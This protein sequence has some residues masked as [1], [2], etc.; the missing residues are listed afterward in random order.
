MMVPSLSAIL[1]G[2]C[3]FPSIAFRLDIVG[4]GCSA[5]IT[6]I[7]AATTF[8]SQHPSTA[9]LV[10]CAEI[11]S[12]LFSPPATVDEMIVNALFADAAAAVTIKADGHRPP[13]LPEILSFA[14]SLYPQF[15]GSMQFVP[16]EAGHGWTFALDRRVSR[17][18]GDAAADTVGRLL[19]GADVPSS[20]VVHWLLHGGG[21]GVTQAVSTSLRIPLTALSDTAATIRNFGNVSSCSVIFALASLLTRKA[22]LPGDYG[23]MIGIG[24]GASIETA[25]LRW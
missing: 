3:A 24:P 7:R 9:A 16:Q 10:V 20:A 5:A 12:S 11:C 15:S 22:P 23:V 6:A 14:S 13:M 8:A 21:P 4:M 19:C 17:W 25:L 1:A 18:V 2:T